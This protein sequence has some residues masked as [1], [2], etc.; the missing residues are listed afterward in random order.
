LPL[1]ALAPGDA[2]GLLSAY[3]NTYLKEEIREEGLVRS[4]APFLRFLEIAGLLNGQTVNAVNI[5]REAAV[6]RTNVDSYFSIL[7]DTLLGHFLCAYR[8]RVK[9]REVAHPK[10][11]WFDSGIARAAA[12]LLFDPADRQWLGMALETLVYH[13]LRVYNQAANRHRPIFYYRTPA[14]VEI[15]FVIETSKRRQDTSA[16]VVCI[17]TKLAA[18]WRREYEKPM[19]ILSDAGGNRVV[20]DRMI[21]VYTGTRSYEFDGISVLPLDRFLAQLHA[22]EIF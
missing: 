5:A 4:L 3:F 18:N 14:G 16:H 17:E 21:G 11:Y 20:V 7:V 19:R 13:E 15:D 9:V 2:P 8:P 12:G 22:G 6:P 1:V 10:F